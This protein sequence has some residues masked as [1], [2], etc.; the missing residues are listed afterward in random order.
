MAGNGDLGDG[1]ALEGGAG[2]LRGPGSRRGGRSE[3]APPARKQRTG[4]RQFVRECTAELGK[5]QWPT[6]RHLWQASA[7]VVV[8]TVVL[9]VYIALLDSVLTRVASWLIDQYAAH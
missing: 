9:G 8:V 2:A 7:V 6:R 5:V 4:F 3:A 1:D